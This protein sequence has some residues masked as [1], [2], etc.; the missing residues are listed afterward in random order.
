MIKS[1]PYPLPQKECVESKN[2][3][4]FDVILKPNASLGFGG[5][6]LLMIGIS[7]F[8]LIAGLGFLV[9]GAWPVLGFFGLDILLIYLAFTINY[10]RARR[11]ERISLFKRFLVV[12]KV[13]ALGRINR[14][15]VEPSWLRVEVVNATKHDRQL[16]LSSHGQSVKIGSFL[17]PKERSEL[18]N[19]LKKALKLRVTP[20][21]LLEQY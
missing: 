5:F 9:L 10:R 16:V 15:Q 21:H 13:S 1:Y 19:V 11:Y 4:F 14:W 3:C 8:G 2:P 7:V 20:E 12:D 17:A 18:A 6:W